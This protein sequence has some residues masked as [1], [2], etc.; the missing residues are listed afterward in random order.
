[1][2]VLIAMLFPIDPDGA[3]TTLA[4]TIHRINGPLA[5]LSLTASVILLSRRFKHDEAWRPFHRSALILSLIMLAL[6][7]GTFVSMATGSGLAGLSQRMYLATFVTWFLLTAARL[8][9]AALD[10]VST[11]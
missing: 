11:R 1:M 6:F 3:S 8:H 9:S 10:P 4:G 2:G 7:M 5:F